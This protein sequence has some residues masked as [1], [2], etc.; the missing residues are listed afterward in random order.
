[1]ATDAYLFFLAE[2]PYTIYLLILFSNLKG[3]GPEPWGVE[4]A[5]RAQINEESVK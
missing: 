5:G 4:A 2:T 3:E 1:M